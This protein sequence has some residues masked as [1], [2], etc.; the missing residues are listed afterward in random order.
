MVIKHVELAGDIRQRRSVGG[1]PGGDYA[2]LNLPWDV[3]LLIN[4][5][6]EFMLTGGS[7]LAILGM[8]IVITDLS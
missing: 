4:V 5:S 7:W 8:T 6:K 3:A 2:A 1:S